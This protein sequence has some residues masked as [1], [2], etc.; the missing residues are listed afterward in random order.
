M[1]VFNTGS[2][3]GK[4]KYQKYY[5]LVLSAIEK[6]GGELIATEKGNYKQI[7]SEAEKAKLPTERLI[8]YEAI[9]KGI[10]W[11]DAVIIEISH[12]DFQLGHEA[13]LAI[14]AKKPVL[15]LSIH[16]DF[17]EKINNRYFFGAKYNE[18][19]V[20]EIVEGFIKR[21]QKNILSE[22]FNCFLSP[23]E[24]QYLESA[25]KERKMNKSEYLRGLID[26]D[27]KSKI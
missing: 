12:E 15:C 14:Q 16:E 6:T 24:V 4:K 19:T 11:A 22:R 7:L 18:Y 26:K 25:A 27:Q 10:L 13:T 21:A 9:R 23:A 20:E 17:S 5:D 3:Y 8:H 2:F 1:K